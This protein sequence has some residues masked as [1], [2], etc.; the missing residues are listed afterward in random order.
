MCD[1]LHLFSR[2][3]DSTS[4]QRMKALYTL[5]QSGIAGGLPSSL[6]YFV[7]SQADHLF[8]LDLIIHARLSYCHRPRRR[9]LRNLSVSVESRLG[10][11]H[12]RGDQY[13]LH[14]LAIIVPQLRPRP[15]TPALQHSHIRP[16]RH[17]LY[18][19]DCPRTARSSSGAHVC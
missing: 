8:Y 6:Y 5:P 15:V 11:P 13:R 7:G 2:A 18:Q 16:L 14:L 4:M 12:L 10:K 17:C 1:S 9:K 19:S 3:F